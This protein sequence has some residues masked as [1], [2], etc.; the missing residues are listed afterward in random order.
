MITFAR[1]RTAVTV[2]GLLTAACIVLNMNGCSGTSTGSRTGQFPF[3]HV[4]VIVQENRTPD[5][6]FQDPVLISRGADIQNYGVNSQGQTITL[7]PWTLATNFDPDH[8]HKAFVE[9]YDGG[10]M[11]GANLITITCAAGATNCPPPN[12]QFQYVMPSDVQPYF[13]MAEQYTFGDRMFQTNQGPS[14]PAHQF[15]I[16]GTSAPTATSNLLAAE[17]PLP[18]GAI[19]AGCIAQSNETVALISPSGDESQTMY[20]CFEH[21][22][23]TDLLSA[24]NIS[25]KYYAPQAGSIWTAPDAIQ[26]MCNPQTQNGQLVCTGSIWNNVIVPPPTNHNQKQVLTDIANNQLATVSWVI[27]GAPESDHSYESNGSGPSWVAAIVNAIGNSPYWSDTAILITWDDWGG[28]YDHV[29]PRV[30][31]SYEYGFRVPL[32]V[33]SPYAKPRYISHVTHDFGSILKFIE[34]NY[35]LPSLGY[36]DALADD[37]SDCFN[38]SQTPL[39]FQTIPAP[40]SASQFLSDTR[41]EAGPD[42]D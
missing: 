5:N 30:M 35:A 3:Q 8:S 23:L 18:F 9:M 21:Q 29:A 2:L 39:T 42:N 7:V 38:F 13:Q 26:H 19:N 4:V 41:P 14:F 33:V 16:A 34:S 31:S 22:T 27:P 15:I 32:V 25:W 20:P 6:L 12:P 36:A 1:L 24:K 10:K 28:W 11:D 40:I 37:L 17:N